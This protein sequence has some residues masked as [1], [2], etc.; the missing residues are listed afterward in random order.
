M[1]GL[2]KL[3]PIFIFL[4]PGI[5]GWALFKKFPDRFPLALLPDGSINGDMVFPMLVKSLLPAGVRGLIVACLLAALM[6]SLASLFNSSASLFTVDIYE[7]LFPN[8]SEKHL[9][10]VGRVATTVVVAAGIVWIPVMKIISSGGLYQY[11]QSVQGYLAPS[12][13]A[14]FIFGIFWRRTNEAGA[15]WGLMTGFVLGMLKLGIQSFFG[16]GADKISSPEILAFIGDFNP[17]YAAGVI[18]AFSSAALIAASL[19]TAE[20]PKEKLKGLTYAWLMSD[21]EARAEIA[22]SWSLSNKIL[23]AS[24]FGG[25]AVCYLYFSFWLG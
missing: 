14:V 23:A 22:K 21:S 16:F 9:L 12:I 4:I 20:P 8:K 3:T 7:K 17:Y 25:V 6:S 19:A 15:V 18:F 11:L 13:T 5:I 24:V 10:F 1:G 2:L